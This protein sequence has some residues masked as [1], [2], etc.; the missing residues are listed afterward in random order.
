MRRRSRNRDP[1]ATPELEQTL[2]PEQ[3]QGA[4][5]GIRV[6]PQHGGEILGRRKP[7]PRLRFAFGDRPSDLAGDLLVQVGRV[8]LVVADGRL[9]ELG[10]GGS[11]V[12]ISRDGRY[13]AWFAKVPSGLGDATGGPGILTVYDLIGGQ[14]VTAA[15]AP[16][17]LSKFWD[18]W[19]RV[20]AIDQRGR[21]YAPTEHHELLMYNIAGYKWV[22]VQGLPEGWMPAHW[23]GSVMSYPTNDGF[24]V[25]VRQASD[26]E[27]VAR[28]VEGRVTAEGRF[29]PVRE[30]PIGKAAWSPDGSRFVQ[31]TAEGFWVQPA[32][33]FDAKVVLHLPF[34]DPPDWQRVWWDAQW[35]SETTVLLSL[36]MTPED[37]DVEVDP[38]TGTVRCFV[39]TGHCE[40]LVGIDVPLSNVAD[41]GG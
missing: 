6:H 36:S 21:V 41:P 26:S 31:L 40:R 8:G 32:H 33:D 27:P 5:H 23:D 37:P 19:P 30:V 14:Q 7:F 35:E 15:G 10:A 12:R 1:T 18:W 11:G 22:E 24:A 29:L 34:R 16:S 39:D 28:S 17:H 20:E 25:A 2:I 13:V 9:T 38:D 4:Q 3:A